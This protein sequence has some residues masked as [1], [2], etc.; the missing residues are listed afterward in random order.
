MSATASAG[1]RSADAT[2]HRSG[3]ETVGRS[4]ARSEYTATVVL[5]SSFWLQSTKTLPARRRFVMR[6]VIVSGDVRSS[7]SATA[8]ANGLVSS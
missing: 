5:C 3:V 7:V 8:L 4:R 6:D 2:S 1:S